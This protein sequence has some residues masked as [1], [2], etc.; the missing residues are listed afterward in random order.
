MILIRVTHEDLDGLQILD[1]DQ[2]R[3]LVQR[4][5]VGRI[6]LTHRAMPLILPVTFGFAHPDLIISVGAGVLADAAA[7]SQIV[8]FEAGWL[9]PETIA[10]W[11]VSV[12]G[13]LSP[14][15]TDIEIE[16]AHELGIK[17]WSSGEQRY[18]RLSPQFTTG[19][20]RSLQLF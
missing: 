18:A 17:P 6:A 3:L 2:C 15:V 20:A 7:Q 4:V 11:S 10:S 5:T 14:L 9:D 12:I 8:C 19:R 1:E 13:Q 16:R